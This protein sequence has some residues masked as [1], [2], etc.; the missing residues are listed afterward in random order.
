MRR[1]GSLVLSALLMTFA[2]SAHADDAAKKSEPPKKEAAP[3]KGT[4]PPAGSKLA[5]VEK[6]MSP[7]Q[8]REIMGDPDNEKSYVTGQAFNPFNYGGNSGANVEWSYK[9]VGRVVF[10]VH[11]WTNKLVVIRIDYDPTEKGD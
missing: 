4:P 3:P 9:G 6:K 8:V 2:A 7:E 11:R 1:V 10:A 5:K